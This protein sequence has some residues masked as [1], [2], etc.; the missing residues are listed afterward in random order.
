MKRVICRA[1]PST[2]GFSLGRLHMGG[3]DKAL[4]GGGTHEG[5]IGLMQGNLTLI[6]Y[7]INQKYCYC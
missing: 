4:M 2:P 6:D 7:I 3:G 5:D 1:N